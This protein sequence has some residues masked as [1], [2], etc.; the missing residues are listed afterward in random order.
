MV[1]ADFTDN[2]K[3]KFADCADFAERKIVCGTDFEITV[4]YI[5]NLCDKKYITE[6]ILKPISIINSQRITNDS[7]TKTLAALPLAEC[8]NEQDAVKK[9]LSGNAVIAINGK[10]QFCVYA[11]DSKS[12]DGRSISEPESEAVVRGP[13]QG[14]VESA[15]ANVTLLRKIIK[16][17]SLKVI[18]FTFGK[19][20]ATSVKVMYYDG[21]VRKDVLKRLIDKLN[22]VKMPSCVDSGYLEQLLQS[23]KFYLFS[24]VGNS[25]KP[26]KIASKILGGRIA[27]ICDGSPV[28][29]TAPYLFTESIQ[30]AEDYLKNIYYASFIRLLRFLGMIIAIYLPSVYIAMLEF[31]KGA[32]PFSLYKLQSGARNNVPF[33]LFTETLVVL[34]VFEIVREVG[35]RMPKAV[36]DALSV[37][38]GLILGDAAIEAGL[39]SETVVVIAAL[40]G[41]CNFMNPTYMNVNVLL[42]FVNLFLAKAFGFFGISA[43]FLTLLSILCSKKSFGVP[44]MFPFA[45][46][47]KQILADTIIMEPNFAAE[48]EQTEILK[49]D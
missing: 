5:I 33:D 10:L 21:I 48:N 46:S 31:H 24:E 49:K 15:E 6:S 18:D 35:V 23:K 42:R 47:S 12:E 4:F 39:T 36:G 9:I 3:N 19:N 13:R 41:I 20:T 22:N 16:S 44:Y 40:T 2:I 34:F 45:P 29:L 17:E 25:E 28:V 43:G 27:I 8:A 37:V 26:D 11:V 7:V 30:S 38:G 1:F 32:L 14:F